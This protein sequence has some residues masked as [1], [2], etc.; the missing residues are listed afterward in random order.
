MSDS[1]RTR[2][3]SDGNGRW[4]KTVWQ[5]QCPEDLILWG[6][7]QGTLGHEG[8]HWAFRGNGS[9]CYHKPEGGG[10]MIPPG[11][12]S[13]VSPVDKVKD[14]HMNFCTVHEV[15]DPDEIAGLESGTIP[16]NSSIVLP[17]HWSE[18]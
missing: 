17:Y 13:W 11:H 5:K 3:V 4:Q 12:S 15:T 2:Y 6:Q 14:Y 9:Y 10:G 18:D 1:L 16:D 8:D 7:C